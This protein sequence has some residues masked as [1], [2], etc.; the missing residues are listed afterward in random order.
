MSGA[1]GGSKSMSN[2]GGSGK[3]QQNYDPTQLKYLDDL[4]GK[5]KGMYGYND[6]TY[7]R[8]ADSVGKK[9]NTL[10]N[11]ALA[12]RDYLAKGGDY[13]KMNLAKSLSNTLNTSL[14][15]PS[16]TSE[17]YS[18]MMGGNGNTYA[19]AMKGSFMADANRVKDN[20]LAS[21][22]ARAAGAGM[23]GSSRH[24]VAQAQGLYDVNS[25]L[26]KNLAETGYNTFDK[27]LQNKLGIAQQADAN[28]LSRQQMLS[29]MLG[30]QNE[31][32]T[33]T[34]NNTG[35]YQNN[36][37]SNFAPYMLPWQNVSQYKNAIGTPNVMSSGSSSN[38]GSSMGGGKGGSGGIK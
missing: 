31:T 15:S 21:L 17:I 26:Q 2:F 10:T 27:D 32:R 11:K 3:F 28:T 12:N 29:D 34:L 25:N 7:K 5:A 13:Q 14:S 22:D 23:G 16:K 1:A 38:S 35:Q 19:D 20:M 36:V 37:M 8:V 33:N 6:A 9:T 18:K 30:K 4:W 24:G